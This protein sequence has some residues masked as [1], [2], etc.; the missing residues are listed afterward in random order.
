MVL[1]HYMPYENSPQYLAYSRETTQGEQTAEK[2]NKWQILQNKKI[3]RTRAIINIPSGSGIFY[4]L[5][6]MHHLN[7]IIIYTFQIKLSF[8]V[9][10]KIKIVHEY[11]ACLMSSIGRA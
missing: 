5:D 11:L 6:N 7:I 10:L 8:I 1:W 9:N 2:Q 4:N 3:S